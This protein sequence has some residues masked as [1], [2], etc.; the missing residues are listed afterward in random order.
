MKNI[1][2]PNLDSAVTLSASELNAIHFSPKKTL[3]SPKKLM[4]G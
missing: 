1:P 4:K 2:H 3:L